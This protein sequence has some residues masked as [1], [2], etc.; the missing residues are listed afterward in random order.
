MS[1]EATRGTVGEDGIYFRAAEGRYTVPPELKSIRKTRTSGNLSWITNPEDVNLSLGNW[2]SDPSRIIYHGGKYHMWMIDLD[3]AGCAEGQYWA[4]SDFFNT[5]VGREFRPKASRILYLSSQDTHHW[6][7][8]CHLPLG[9]QGS[10]YD[11]LLE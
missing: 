4:N 11:L 6:T 5:P 9:P 10:C 1:Q 2:Q 7:A 8:H 3:R